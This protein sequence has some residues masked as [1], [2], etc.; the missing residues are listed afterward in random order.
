MTK[1]CWNAI[2]RNESARI[3]RCM[4]SLVDHIDCYVVVDTGSSDDTPGIIRRFFEERGIP[5]EVHHAPFVDFEQARNDA[6][7]CARSSSLQYD[8]MLLVDADM[9]LVVTDQLWASNLCHLS[10]DMTQV[11]G[12]LR[13]SNRRLVRRS[14][15]G[16]YVGVTHEYLDIASGGH[17]N[18]AYF[19]DH[20]DGA[21]RPNKYERD[22]VLLLGA[23]EKDPTNGRYWYYLGQSYRDAGK[24]YLAANAYRRCVECG[25]WD[26]QVWSAQY[27]Y[28]HCLE[29]MGDVGGFLREMMA[30]YNMRPSRA[31][32][33]YD[34]AKYYREKN[35]Q[36]VGVLFAEQG[37]TI[38][39]CGDHLFV[40]QFV[41]DHGLREE[42]SICGFYD[43]KRRKTA[44][45]YCNA[46]ALDRRAPWHTREGAR[47]N[48]YFY[49]GPLAAS[50]FVSH[51]RI[52]FEAPEGYVPMNPSVITQ[53]N[54][55]IRA[56]V[57]T[58]NY[59]ITDSGHYAI[60]GE[61]GECSMYN[62]I[63]TRNFLVRLSDN[64]ELVESTEIVAPTGHP[65]PAYHLVR[66]FEDMRLYQHRDALWVSAC[67]RELNAE[68]WCEQMAA[69][70]QPTGELI[71][72]RRMI[73]DGAR[74][75]EKNWMPIG[76][77][78]WVY[79]LGKLVD[80]DGATL[81]DVPVELDT[82]HISGGAITS[83]PCFYGR[84][85]AVVH[86]ARV[87]PDNG[88]RYYQ[89]RFARIKDDGCTVEDISRPFVFHDK[90]IE[91]AAGISLHP[92][93]ERMMISYGV[94]DKEAWIATVAM[95]DVW[96]VF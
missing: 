13:Y 19:V 31:E 37:L 46:L 21:N 53:A 47:S 1:L 39:P 88:Q 43:S 70:I 73:P 56:V 29:S 69:R 84:Y 96:K 54:G 64:F 80:W 60:R 45:R 17:V 15:T 6:L 18:G 51:H 34:L 49:V 83:T 16:L 8:Y 26:E 82:D 89:H 14:A 7:K 4:R 95:K 20:A 62:P 5:G 71:A 67:V 41:W 81:A 9:E 10:Y 52:P 30:A 35:M 24:H 11:A 85:L 12:G 76:D 33:L 40:S 2:V 92:D 91:F 44:E 65:E 66:G 86:E 90:Q 94:R 36:H 77:Q 58:V 79:R 23:V 22:I 55:W 32:A 25:G 87:R 57:R 74:Q 50:M 42:Y 68:G 27:N 78:R 59:T 75:H 38:P 3:E 28:A 63:H 48:L 93:G 72:L 61:D